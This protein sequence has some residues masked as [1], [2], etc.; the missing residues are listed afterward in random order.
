MSIPAVFFEVGTVDVKMFGLAVHFGDDH[1]AFDDGM[2]ELGD[3]VVFGIVGIKIRF[4][5]KS[6][7]ERDV[8]IDGAAELDGFFRRLLC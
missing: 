2:V 1:A 4:S 6:A 8:G 7:E 3:L 5:V